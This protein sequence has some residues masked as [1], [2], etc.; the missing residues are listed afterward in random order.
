MSGIMTEGGRI[1]GGWVEGVGLG[2]WMMEAGMVDWEVEEITMAMVV[3]VE[4][5]TG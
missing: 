3:G 4:A 5:E 1:M 2:D